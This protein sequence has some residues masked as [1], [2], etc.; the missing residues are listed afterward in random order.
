MRVKTK[1]LLVT[2]LLVSTM[3]AI[4]AAGWWGV[5]SLAEDLRQSRTAADALRTHVEG[6]MMHDTLRGDV[7]GAIL[8]AQS[9]D[10]KALAEAEAGTREHVENFRRL[11]KHNES[12][13]LPGEVVS[14]LGEV[15]ERLDAYLAAAESHV[16]LAKADHRAALA[17]LPEFIARFTALE[18]P[19]SDVSDKISAHVERLNERGEAHA[20]RAEMVM[21][22]LGALALLVVLAGGAIIIS[23]LLSPMTALGEVAAVLRRLQSG[24]LSVQVPATDRGDEVGDVAKAVEIFRAN[25]RET[26]TLKSAQEQQRKSAA[27]DAQSVLHRM[28][29]DFE[30]SVGEV[31]NDVIGSAESL[32]RESDSLS[33]VASAASGNVTAVNQASQ[34]ATGSVTNVAHAT[35]EMQSSIQEIGRQVSLSTQAAQDAVSQA[36]R[37]NATVA[38]LAAAARKVGEV[39]KI[40]SDIANQTNLLA[41]NATIE[42]ARAGE[43]GKGFAVVAN[44]VKSLANQTGK[45]TEDISAQITEIQTVAAD[46]ASAIDGIGGAIDK[47]SRTVSGIATAIGEQELATNEISRSAQEAAAG[48]QT[49]AGNIQAM[50]SAAAETGESARQLQATA[51]RLSSQSGRLQ[52]EVERFVQGVRA[53]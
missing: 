23:G 39:V 27:V 14:A 42:A 49:V 34:R 36:Q 9:G 46:A 16:A 35:V 3:I 28:A 53:G 48:T 47:I 17:R 52:A 51:T 4:G 32:K 26:E 31:L 12:L 43:A 8:A 19:M 29:D 7:T 45:A 2:G 40:I 24:E 6:D 15:R 50:S 33:S 5:E 11:L 20:E 44:E 37:T 22:G 30:R 41:L 10:A 38:S 25:L 21:I 18:G 13:P 1:I